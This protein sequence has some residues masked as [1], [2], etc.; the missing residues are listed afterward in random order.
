[1]QELGKINKQEK[2]LPGTEHHT[3]K[4][5]GICLTKDQK[6]DINEGHMV[7]LSH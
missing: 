2:K 5:T 4:Y 7:Y 3:N 1:M 6:H